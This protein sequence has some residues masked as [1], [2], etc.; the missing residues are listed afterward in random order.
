LARNSAGDMT[1]ISLKRIFC[2]SYGGP[3]IASR[4]KTVSKNERK[5]D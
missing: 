2:E 3:E 5:P 4:K 1:V